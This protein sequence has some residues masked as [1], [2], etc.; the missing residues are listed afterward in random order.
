[1]VRALTCVLTLVAGLVAG[2]AEADVRK[3]WQVAQQVLP[4]N[5]HAVIAIDVA[6]AVRTRSFAK[7]FTLLRHEEHDLGRGYDRVKRGCGVDPVKAIDGLVIAGEPAAHGPSAVVIAQVAVA[8]AKA[9]SCLRALFSDEKGI[10]VADQGAYTIASKGSAHI[11]FAW[12]APDVVAMAIEPFDKA[13]LDRWTQGKGAFARS[14]V[15]GL[16]GKVDPK[17]VVSGAFAD[18]KPIS[19]WIPVT[20]AWGT[21]ALVRGKLTGALVLTSP[22]AKTATQLAA[23]IAQ[24]R[25]HEAGRKRTP[26]VVKRVLR[27]IDVRAAGTD[28]TIR[29]SVPEA[30]L[31]D[32]F[33][34]SV[35][36]KQDEPKRPQPAPVRSR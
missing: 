22:D 33:L 19:A 12:L 7:V 20:R 5:T 8:R 35:A 36:P 15:A 9:V 24:E 18:T 2:R 26:A 25:D 17:L 31:G 11:Y 23:E 10:T 1:M 30:L 3:A 27:A 28:V 29:G 21:L 34:A 4:A 13:V 6:A 32:A 14:A 16:A